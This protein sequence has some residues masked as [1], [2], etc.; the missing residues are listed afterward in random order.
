MQ[1]GYPSHH[2]YPAAYDRYLRVI[3]N[4]LPLKSLCP[5]STCPNPSLLHFYF[6]LM[7]QTLTTIQQARHKLCLQSH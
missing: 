6:P 7:T 4:R 1:V 5:R 2:C 3:R